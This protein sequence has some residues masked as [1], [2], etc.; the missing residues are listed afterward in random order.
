MGLCLSYHVNLG[1]SLRKTAEAL[2]DIHNIK[3]SHTMVANYARTAAV[4]IKPFV[5]NFY[6]L[7][8]EENPAFKQGLF[9]LV[10][11]NC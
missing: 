10:F 11:Y 1:L 6:N 8:R 7:K 9:S 4:I 5:D 3:I 2:R